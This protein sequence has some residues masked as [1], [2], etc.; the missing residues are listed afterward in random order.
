MN[1]N[2]P[3]PTTEETKLP[4]ATTVSK[5]TGLR[6]WELEEGLVIRERRNDS[7][8]IGFRLDVPAKVMGSRQRIQFADFHEA[9]CKA[10]KI[11]ADKKQFGL[12][13]FQLTKAQSDD[14]AKALL[15]LMPFGV[16]LARAAEYF[17]KHEKAQ[18]GD[19]N[20]SRL[21]EVF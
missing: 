16:T 4:R 21:V 2:S 9:N 13:G 8:S 11:L 3:T 14:A 17:A 6:A 7:G 15:I 12:S 18:K 20:L 10:E 19:V 5:E 1:T